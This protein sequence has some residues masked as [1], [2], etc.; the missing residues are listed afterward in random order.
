MSISPIIGAPNSF[1][2]IDEAFVTTEIVEP[3]WNKNQTMS[4]AIPEDTA[5]EKV[6][7][8]EPNASGMPIKRTV[9]LPKQMDK[10]QDPME[11]F[12][13]GSGA[14]D[15]TSEKEKFVE[16]PSTQPRPID[17]QSRTYKENQI[18]SPGYFQR[19]L[20]VMR[21]RRNS[22]SYSAH[23]SLRKDNLEN[24]NYGESSHSK[25]LGTVSSKEIGS[26]Q[27][28]FNMDANLARYNGIGHPGTRRAS[29]GSADVRSALGPVDAPYNIYG[30][31]HPSA[32]GRKGND[33]HDTIIGDLD[34][35]YHNALDS[36]KHVIGWDTPNSEVARTQPP[37]VV[38]SASQN[39]NQLVAP[40][41]P[42]EPKF[43]YTF[44][45]GPSSPP[46]QDHASQLK[47]ST[48]QEFPLL[49]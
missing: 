7:V 14:G 21:G 16:V 6:T 28:S 23:T 36:L 2:A 22:E 40:R 24:T 25:S 26:T 5:F 38:D 35:G 4:T 10:N 47:A 41:S 43:D 27:G 44:R 33:R 9:E 29:L 18:Y 39:I 32:V 13:A 19:A 20:D 11:S 34:R 42:A 15:Y 17:T 30:S 8:T 46:Q 45:N 49:I 1:T 12:L 31:T 37:V 48:D 3:E